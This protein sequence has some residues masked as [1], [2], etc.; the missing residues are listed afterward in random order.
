MLS[1]PKFYC[2]DEGKYERTKRLEEESLLHSKIKENSIYALI[3]GGV[4]GALL[5]V[6]SLSA[7][8]LFCIF[9]KYY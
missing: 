7:L 4:L 6:M 2:G 9:K 8:S 5:G 1:K 3:R